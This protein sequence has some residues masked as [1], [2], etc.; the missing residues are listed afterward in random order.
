MTSFG[1]ER[2]SD[3]AGRTIAFSVTVGASGAIAL[4]TKGGCGSAEPHERFATDPIASVSAWP[5]R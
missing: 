3:E 4:A 2:V 1:D 5:T